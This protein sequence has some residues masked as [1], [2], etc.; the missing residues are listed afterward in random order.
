MLD[1][2]HILSPGDW[3][4]ALF[5]CERCPR[6]CRPKGRE[7]LAEWSQAKSTGLRQK[8]PRAKAGGETGPVCIPAPPFPNCVASGKWL[9]LSETRFPPLQKGIHIP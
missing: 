4:A 9:N 1:K 5:P 3:L 2:Y 7:G 8:G 6:H